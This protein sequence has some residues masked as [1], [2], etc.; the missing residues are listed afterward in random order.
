MPPSQTAIV[1]DAAV[2]THLTFLFE[3][4]VIDVHPPIG[5]GQAHLI[6][7]SLVV[8]VTDRSIVA[9]ALGAPNSTFTH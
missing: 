4:I 8:S 3:H 1:A 9:N 2:R 6:Q 7:A 5:V